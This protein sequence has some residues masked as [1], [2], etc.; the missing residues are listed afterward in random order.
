MLPGYCGNT[1]SDN[2]K[3]KSK[4]GAVLKYVLYEGS[5]QA[6]IPTT[7]GQIVTLYDVKDLK[8]KVNKRETETPE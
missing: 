1:K 7:L 6:K 3:Q 8:K 4:L 5:N 2:Q